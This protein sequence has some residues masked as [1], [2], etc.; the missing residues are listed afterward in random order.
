[1]DLNRQVFSELV[2]NVENVLTL[3]ESSENILRI[4]DLNNKNFRQSRTY[5]NIKFPVGGT[6][7]LWPVNIKKILN[8]QF[9]QQTI[10]W[11]MNIKIDFNFKYFKITLV[12]VELLLQKCSQVQHFLL[13][14]FRKNR[15]LFIRRKGERNLLISIPEYKFKARNASDPRNSVVRVSCQKL[16]RICP[17]R[18]RNRILPL[19]RNSRFVIIAISVHYHSN[20]SFYY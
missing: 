8:A 20:L 13:Q 5:K 14:K 2:P 11:I 6:D 15:F 1:M 7:N 9:V 12:P 19:I 10:Q 17:F 18:R 3:Q 4:K 16:V